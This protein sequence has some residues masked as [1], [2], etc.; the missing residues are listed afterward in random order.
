MRPLLEM[1]L[2]WTDVFANEYEL[3]NTVYMEAYVLIWISIVTVLCLKFP[4][5]IYGVQLS[6]QYVLKCPQRD[7][8][9]PLWS[10]RYE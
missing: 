3:I 2:L 5:F 7:T 9:I 1:S 8:F 10:T 6:Y 4:L